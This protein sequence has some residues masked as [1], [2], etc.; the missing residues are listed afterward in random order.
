M[1]TIRQLQEQLK[2][3]K[4]KLAKYNLISSSNPENIAVAK[5]INNL[6]SLI[7]AAGKFEREK[8][9][10]NVRNIRV[11]IGT[12]AYITLGHGRKYKK[13]KKIYGLS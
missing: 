6:G 1:P 11:S 7:D 4:R 10:R 8:Q 3:W 2:K 9:S 5:G 12:D 13:C